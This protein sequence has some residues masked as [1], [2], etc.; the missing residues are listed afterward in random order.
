MY[1]PEPLNPALHIG[2]SAIPFERVA[3]YVGNLVM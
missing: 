1:I 2:D 3:V